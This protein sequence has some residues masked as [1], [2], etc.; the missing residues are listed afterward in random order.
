MWESLW[1]ALNWLITTFGGWLL[2]MLMWVIEYVYELVNEFL[3]WLYSYVGEMA[4]SF[5]NRIKPHI[6][7]NLIDNILGAYQWLEYINEYVPVKLSI[8]LLVAYYGIYLIITI[9]RFVK[10]WI[11]FIG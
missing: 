3:S 4:I 7:G 2:D 11:P 5:L 9:Y 10:S 6:P 8:S 1:E